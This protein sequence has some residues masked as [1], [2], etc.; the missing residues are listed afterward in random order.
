VEEAYSDWKQFDGI[1]WP[2]R[3]VVKRNGRRTEDLRVLEAKF[4]SGL[5][6]EQLE[7]RP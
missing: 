5:T 6:A 7:R 3:I 4:N 2:G 1:G